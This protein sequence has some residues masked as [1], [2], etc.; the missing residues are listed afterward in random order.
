MATRGKQHV[1]STND[2]SDYSYRQTIADYYQVAANSKASLKKLLPVALVLQL[3]LHSAAVFISK[4]QPLL[5]GLMSSIQLLVFHLI[6][7]SLSQGLLFVVSQSTSKSAISFYR[8]TLLNCALGISWAVSVL[9]SVPAI[10][11]FSL[12]MTPI[13]VSCLLNAAVGYHSLKLRWAW[14]ETPNT[15]KKRR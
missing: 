8:V 13:A 1:S 4:A 14:L 12:T 2:G 15:R 9:A 6:A 5:G 11:H 7:L 10:I 3:V